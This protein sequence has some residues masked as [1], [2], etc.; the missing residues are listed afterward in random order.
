MQRPRGLLALPRWLLTTLHSMPFSMLGGFNQ[1]MTGCPFSLGPAKTTP[2]MNLFD[3]LQ[4]H[5]SLTHCRTAG[6]LQMYRAWCPLKHPEAR[7]F[8]HLKQLF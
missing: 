1:C 3:C 6:M 7:T 2:D 4:D 8:V 5:M